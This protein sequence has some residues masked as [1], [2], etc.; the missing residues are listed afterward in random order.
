[1]RYLVLF[2]LLA[3]PRIG[4]QGLDKLALSPSDAEA[5]VDSV[6]KIYF[7]AKFELYPDYATSKGIHTYDDRLATFSRKERMTF[8]RRLMRIEPLLE[9]F[10]VDSLPMASWLDYEFLKRDIAIQQFWLDDVKIWQRSPLL[11]ADACIN[12]IYNLLIKP[13]LDDVEGKVKARL[14]R[15][16]EVIASAKANL[17]DPISLHCEVAADR[18][19][20]FAEF[21]GNLRRDPRLASLDPDLI[22]D[23]QDL[24]SAFASYCDSL[25]EVGNPAFALGR[26]N[27]IHLLTLEGVNRSPEQILKLALQVLE[28]AKQQRQDLK[29]QSSGS[30]DSIA[31]DLTREDIIRYFYAEVESAKVFLR[32]RQIVTLGD[33]GEVRIVETPVFLRGLIPGYAYE[34]P[35]PFDS[36]QV[37]YFYVPL[38]ESLDATTSQKFARG[39]TSRA[40]AGAVVHEAFPGHH[41]QFVT[42]SHLPSFIRRMTDNIFTI[43]GW[44]FYCEEMMARQGYYGEEGMARA[45]GG[46]IFRAARAVVDV[47][48]QLGD[49][50]LEDAVDFMVDQTGI[51]RD[52]ATAEV[53]RYAV[54]PTQAMSYLLGKQ[55]IVEIRD[56]VER[57]RGE[58]FDIRHFHD[59]LL[60]CGAL[61]PDLLETCV[62]S[63]VTGKK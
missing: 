56:R 42:R 32:R 61:P 55:K 54:S 14:S 35:G 24:I 43:E 8:R 11:Y 60:G 44:A 47:R 25:A 52:F 20:D 51:S 29:Q 7:R 63:E 13:D 23:S 62:I 4:W 50:T 33:T 41:L 58:A 39:I 1:L 21:V 3:I 46:I 53:R 40:F 45:L 31:T 37:G 48:L 22:S 15:I 28:S 49:F 16:P 36:K 38:P 57:I 34:P 10:V 9:S 5:L 6:G 30:G 18:L 59:V 2:V 27:L 26:E 12:G 19:R 17:T